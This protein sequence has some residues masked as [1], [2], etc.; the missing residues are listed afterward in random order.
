MENHK[1]KRSPS[2]AASPT[3]TSTTRRPFSSR[4]Y[5]PNTPGQTLQPPTP[6]EMARDVELVRCFLY[7]GEGTPSASANQSVFSLG[8]VHLEP[9]NV[10]G[11]HVIPVC[12]PAKGDEEVDELTL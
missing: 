8:K 9:G 12:P 7:D 5:K 11:N 10:F 6:E 4:G 2:N 3:S 1:R